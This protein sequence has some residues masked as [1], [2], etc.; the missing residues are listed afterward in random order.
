MSETV[1]PTESTARTS[2]LPGQAGAGAARASA[3]SPAARV[4]GRL[5]RAAPG[6]GH[7]PEARSSRSLRCSTVPLLCR[8]RA[9]GRDVRTVLMRMVAAG[10]LAGSS[11][12]PPDVK[13]PV[14]LA[15]ARA[16]GTRRLR[17]HPPGSSFDGEIELF[18]LTR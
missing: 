5:T 8:R 13:R 1:I 11:G 4:V 3:K 16:N 2:A 17:P 9:G 18:E 7:R 6:G 15:V 12:T 10:L 14:S